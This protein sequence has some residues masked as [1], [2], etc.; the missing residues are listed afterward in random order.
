MQSDARALA[1]II[2]LRERLRNPRAPMK[3]IPLHVYIDLIGKPYALGARGP[4]SFDCLGLALELGKRLG[5]T[6]PRYLTC[7]NELHRQLAADASTLAD[8][9]RIPTPLPGCVALLRG[10]PGEHHLAVMLD[11]DWMLHTRK[12]TGCVRER[13]AGPL[14]CNKVIGFYEVPCSI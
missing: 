11:R 8:F 2:C 7:E 6:F 5:L 3:V 4:A 9:Q 13:I 10:E 1:E 14:W 12:E